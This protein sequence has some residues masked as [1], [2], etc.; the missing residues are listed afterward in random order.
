MSFTDRKH[1]LA[2]LRSPLNEYQSL[3]FLWSRE[4]SLQRLRL[5][6]SLRK[7]DQLS[8]HGQTRA[9]GAGLLD[10]FWQSRI[11]SRGPGIGRCPV[12]NHEIEILYQGMKKLKLN[13]AYMQ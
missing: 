8:G 2:K 5:K 1:R 13:G 6:S 12:S 9:Q 7:Q 11:T 10:D 4:L 3:R